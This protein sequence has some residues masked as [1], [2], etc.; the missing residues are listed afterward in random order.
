MGSAN[1]T[2]A[3]GIVLSA[4]NETPGGQLKFCSGTTIDPHLV[5][6]QRMQIELKNRC[7][8]TSNGFSTTLEGEDTGNFYGS[9]YVGN[10]HTAAMKTGAKFTLYRYKI[11]KGDE[12]LHD[13]VPAFEVSSGSFGVYDIVGDKGFR[14][15]ADSNHFVSPFTILSIATHSGGAVNVTTNGTLAGSIRGESQTILIS[16]G[17]EVVLKPVPDGKFQFLEWSGTLPPD[18]TSTETILQF[19]NVSEGQFY[20]LTT[21]FCCLPA[22]YGRIS[23]IVSAG[24]SPDSAYLD[25]G[26]TPTGT[27][28]G[29]YMDFVLESAVGSSGPRFM[30]SA[31]TTAA[32]GIVLSAW[33][34]TL[35]GQ[36][37]FCSDKTV[38]PHLVTGRRM[39]IELKNRCYKTS[40]GFSTTLEGEDTG[41]FYGSVYVGNVHAAEMKTGA[42]FT[43]YRY[44]VYKSDDLLHDF[45]PVI[46]I[47]TGTVGVYDIVG[48]KGFLTSVASTP[49]RSPASAL[50]INTYGGSVNV[51]TNG[52]PAGSVS[53]LDETIPLAYGTDVVLTP[54]SDKGSSFVEWSGTIPAGTSAADTPLSFKANTGESYVLSAVFSHAVPAGYQ[55][56]EFI[57]STNSALDSAYIDTD[58]TPTGADFGFYMD[59]VLE[60]AIDSS[61]PRFMGS[62]TTTWTGGILLSAWSDTPGGQL[63]FCSVK[64][65]DPHLVTGQRMQI[66][67]KNG[68][69]FASTTDRNSFL[70]LDATL[71]N[72][73]DGSVY[74]GNIH[75]EEMRAG[76]MFTLFRYKIYKGG[77]LLHDFIP[78][79]ERATGTAGVYDIV[80]DKGFRASATSTPFRHKVKRGLVIM[81]W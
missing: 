40:N 53:G 35:G 49:F 46:E 8:K 64:T 79:V 41:N 20:D 75:T 16:A 61:G 80:G 68:I 36:L 44:K 15:S 29:F 2:A 13:F 31:N 9:V 22:E 18:K 78:V 58:Y 71:D 6:R 28:F 32:G 27:D 45:I 47:A 67:L 11:Y 48:D 17:T 10:V 74:V 60:S 43:L 25:T 62:A 38:D 14:A 34:E 21:S 37:K 33:S 77:L 5:A 4:W 51:M 66:E 65:F 69:Y 1:T 81:F 76:S 73:F 26:Y 30:G 59:F 42:K 54:R 56:A 70:G 55:R 24:S 72:A 39:Q 3:G 57:T 23:S 63:K 12:V 19:F 52:I 7:Y 50:T